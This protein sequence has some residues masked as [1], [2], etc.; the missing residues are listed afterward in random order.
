[1][2]PKLN[3]RVKSKVNFWG[4]FTSR[5]PEILVKNKN[6]PKTKSLGLSNSI[7]TKFQKNHRIVVKLISPLPP[8][9]K[10]K[11]MVGVGERGQKMGIN[12]PLRPGQNSHIAYSIHIFPQFVHTKFQF[13][14]LSVCF[15][16]N[17]TWKIPSAF[18][19]QDPIGSILGGVGLGQYLKQIKPDWVLRL[20]M[21]DDTQSPQISHS[22]WKHF[23]N[24][25]C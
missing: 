3:L 14:S 20:R 11:K 6:P 21:F 9:Q 25:K 23:E 4:Q 7:N 24:S 2:Q 22:H 16:L 17:F 1:M 5:K 8:P 13:L 15:I 19:V 10:K 18:G 12:C